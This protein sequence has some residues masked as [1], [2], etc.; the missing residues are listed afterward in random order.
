MSIWRAEEFIGNSFQRKCLL[1][2]FNLTLK[3]VKPEYL[4]GWSYLEQRTITQKIHYLLAVKKI[5]KYIFLTDH[6]DMYSYHEELLNLNK[7]TYIMGHFLN[8]KYIDPI[9]DKLLQEFT[10]K[11]EL[12]IPKELDLIMRNYDTVSVHIRRGDYLYAECAQIINKEMRRGHYYERAMKYI[13]AKVQNPFF[14]IFSDD[15]EW[16]RQNFI[17]PYRHIYIN[18]MG[19]KD[20]E[21]MMLMSY[22]KH[23]II[24]N[25][26]F[27]FWG[28]WLNKNKKNTV[29]FPKHWLPSIIPE[30]WIPM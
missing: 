1:G 12:T 16:V 25:S 28:A 18:N 8:K 21:E 15:M 5:G 2:Y 4:S 20:Y 7:N 29:I 26:T 3:F 19:F 17:C 27:S 23:N 22:C 11:N 24:A 9:R 10:L 13:A 6:S 14:L 30:R